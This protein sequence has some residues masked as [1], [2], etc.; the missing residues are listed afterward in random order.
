MSEP[1]KNR[2]D[3]VLYV[4]V[5][6]G[7]PNGDPDAGNMPRID[8]ETG[9]GLITD[10]CLKRKV[11]NYIEAACEG[12][13]GYRIYV[14][15]GLTLE[16][17]DQEG[18]KYVGIEEPDPKKRAEKLKK[19]KKDD[20]E[21]DKKLRN[22]MCQN[23][24]D[25][26]AF[27]AVMT[28]FVRG[29]LSCG[30]VRGPIQFG[31]ARSVDPV[32]PQEI[33]ITRSTVTTDK[34]AETKQTMMGRKYIIPYGLY[35]V[36]GYISANLARRITG[37]SEDDLNLFWKALINMFDID[38]SAARGN[39]ATRKLIIFK[40]DSELG[41]APANLLFDRVQAARKNPQ[42]APRAFSDYEITVN[43][44]DLPEGVTCTQMI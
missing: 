31:F 16:S 13:E 9:L 20:P 30:Q 38:R 8:Q 11:R 34:E 10:V 43:T 40:H 37:F 23:F 25:I 41:N 15:E 32:L 44:E 1:I 33:S 12:Q 29:A 26:R 35:R 39:M 19:A 42:Q 27:G 5:E 2:Y 6:N 18:C 17:R 24:F 14:H 36:E 3:F 22:F 21:I 28:T 7:N 4:D